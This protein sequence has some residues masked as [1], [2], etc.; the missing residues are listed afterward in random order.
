MIPDIFEGDP[1][2]E[3]VLT[4]GFTS[5]NGPA[6][7]SKHPVARVD[8]IVGTT[9][10]SVKSEFGPTKLG[11]VGFCFGA[12]YVLRFLA[13]GKGV[14]VGFVAH[15]TG[16]ED[17]EVEGIA[18]PLSIA[19]AEVDQVFPTEKRRASEDILIKGSVPYQVVLYGDTEHGFAVRTDL[20]N[21]KKKFAKESAYFQ[22]VRWFD[23]FL[24]E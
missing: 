4:E 6:W 12:K 1:V 19:A 7:F 22:A 15:P 23:Q 17:A 3:S 16:V 18:G 2:P 11:A 8:E 20:N 13:A 5:F 24:K 10:K 21:P 9:I 14:D